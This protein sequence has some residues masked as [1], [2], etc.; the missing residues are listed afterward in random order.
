MS[1]DEIRVLIQAGKMDDALRELNQLRS[2]TQ[3]DGEINIIEAEIWRQKGDLLKARNLYLNVVNSDSHNIAAWVSLL[4]IIAA[5]GDQ[6]FLDDCFKKAIASNPESHQILN[7]YGCYCS[8][9]KQFEVAEISFKKSL[10][11]KPDFLLALQGLAGVYCRCSLWEQA[12]AVLN[13][14][15]RDH[16]HA[17][18]LH[19]MYAQVCFHLEKNMQALDSIERILSVDPENPQWLIQYGAILEKLMR[20]EASEQAYVKA[21][22]LNPNLKMANFNLGNLY[23][24]MGQLDDAL[25]SYNQVISLDEND[26]NAYLNLGE[27]YRSFELFDDAIAAYQKC[28][29]KNNSLMPAQ[30][31]IFDCL[32][33]KGHKEEA[34]LLYRSLADRFPADVDVAA[35]ASTNFR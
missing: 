30:L 34:L 19:A 10:A 16:N 18:S 8:S 33:A 32:V 28:L 12:F 6:S 4:K 35:L 13:V 17:S 20:Y 14:A 26:F 1:L 7:E 29:E 2:E 27:A 3:M 5:S 31:A 21:L 22:K 25:A 23:V 11:L 15:L 9:R 24:K